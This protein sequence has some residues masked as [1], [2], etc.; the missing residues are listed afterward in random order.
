MDAIE[1]RL[2]GV[3][4]GRVLDVATGGGGFIATLIKSLRRYDEII[5]ID[6]TDKRFDQGCRQFA[7]LPVR[8]M[9]MDAARMGFADGSFDTVTICNSLHHL[10]EPSIIL[11][12]ML[13]VLRP[14]GHLI[15]F[16]MYDDN[17]TEKQLTHI[18]LHRWW[19]EVDRRCGTDHFPTGTRESLVRL[20][21]NLPL[22]SF[23]LIDFAAP[24]KE[25]LSPEVAAFLDKAFVDYLA[26]SKNLPDGEELQRQGDALRC[27]LHEVGFAWATELFV[28]GVK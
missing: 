8:F 21:E 13:R 11:T 20:V 28:V 18:L 27:R 4:G 9:V 17:P 25:P 7:D 2:R 3:D 22:A 14:G 19:A 26:K 15:I 12:E 24:A 16:E 23:E 6:L 5:G 10:A 1:Q